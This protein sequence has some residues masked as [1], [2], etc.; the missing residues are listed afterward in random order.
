MATTVRTAPTRCNDRSP[1]HVPAAAAVAVDGP[2]MIFLPR[3]NDADAADDAV[4]DGDSDAALLL[5]PHIQLAN[6]IRTRLTGRA[7]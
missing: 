2:L 6:P 1:I 7:S 3:Y 4:V 5:A